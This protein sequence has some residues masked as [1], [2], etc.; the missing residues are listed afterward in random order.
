MGV[1]SQQLSPGA[2]PPNSD[3]FIMLRRERNGWTSGYGLSGKEEWKPSTFPSFDEAF[4]A[5]ED[6]ANQVGVPVI[7]HD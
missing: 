7:Y 5:A 6:W 1:Q 4:Y 2:T 3:K